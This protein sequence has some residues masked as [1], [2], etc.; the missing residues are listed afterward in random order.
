MNAAL[1][2]NEKVTSTLKSSITQTF[3]ALVKEIH[4]VMEDLGEDKEE[5]L[6]RI[7]PWSVERLDGTTVPEKLLR[8]I[9]EKLQLDQ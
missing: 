3:T 6:V 5:Y 1:K 7:Y 2:L 4:E 8:G 9:Q